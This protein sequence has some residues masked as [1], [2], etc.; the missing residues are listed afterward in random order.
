MTT[1]RNLYHGMVR[2]MS[3]AIDLYDAGKGILAREVMQKALLDAEEQVIA[4]DIIPD[5]PISSGNSAE[6]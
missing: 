5:E 4:Y 6:N 3:E 1:Y 2:S